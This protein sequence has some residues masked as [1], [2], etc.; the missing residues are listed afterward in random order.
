MIVVTGAN[1]FVGRALLSRLAQAHPGAVR[2]AVRSGQVSLPTGVD[3]ANVGELGP[4]SDWSAAV[5]DAEVVV[6]TAARVHVMRDEHSD[7]LSAYRRANVA[8]TIALARQ[9][10]A[11]RVRRL[12][13]LSSI[14]VNG[15]ETA[16]GRPFAASD[17]P[18]P[19][20]AYGISKLE[21][22]QGLH[23]VAKE[24]GLEVVIIRPVLVYGPGVRANFETMLRW[25]DRGLPLPFGGIHNARSLVSLTNLVDLV[26]R[27]LTHP[28]AAQRTFLVSD[29][30]DL[31]TPALLHRAAGALGRRA[32]LL[33]VP[34][35]MLQWGARLVGR[36]DAAQRLCGSLQV[37]IDATRSVLDWDPPQS[38][39]DALRET[40]R[41]FHSAARG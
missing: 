10:A 34:A 13:F 11:A 18:A 31:S 40:A 26:S 21:A 12:I 30:E 5:R 20:G 4:D 38:I 27:C 29:G 6:H 39:D 25:L 14:K 8:A 16:P 32:R 1:G 19:A 7:P 37:N 9:A 41:H 17:V 33:P 35:S 28:R 3:R 24:T 36:P 23:S 2:G 22:E 15:E